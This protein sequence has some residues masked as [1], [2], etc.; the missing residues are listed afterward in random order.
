MRLKPVKSLVQ[1]DFPVLTR[2]LTIIFKITKPTELARL[3]I[4]CCLQPPFR[5]YKIFQEIR[6]REISKMNQKNAPW[7][8]IHGLSMWSD[9]LQLYYL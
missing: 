8:R 5:W 3:K 1:S 4:F 6:G 2:W 7:L 9:Y